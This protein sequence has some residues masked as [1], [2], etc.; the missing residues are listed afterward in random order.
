MIF[1]G[2][3]T[4]KRLLCVLLALLTLM[5]AVAVA[6][7]NAE[8]DAVLADIF[9]KYKTT[10]AVVVVA[11][12]GEIVYHYD[13]GYAYKK[14]R[15]PITPESYFKIASVTKL[16]SAIRV[17]QLVEEGMLDLDAPIGNYF[18]FTIQN[19]HHRA[20]P[21]TLRHLM[22]HTS[23][24]SQ[25]GGYSRE[26]R[27]DTF[28]DASLNHWSNWED[29]APGSKYAYSNFGA[30]LMGSLME[31]VT[32]QNIDDCVREGVFEPLNIDAAYHISLLGDP[33][34]AVYTYRADG[35]LLSSRAAYMR[36]AWEPEIDPN[37][38]YTITVGSVWIRGDD[39]CRLGIMLC[40]GGTIDG[41][42]ILK[43]ETVE[44]MMSSQQGLGHVTV[45]SP[46]GLCVHRVS[47]L[48]DDYM[49]YGHQGLSEGILCNLYFDPETRLV[50][51]LITNGSST[52]MTDH[53]GR[54]S[55]R[56]FAEIWDRYRD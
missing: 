1:E 23:S 3:K 25:R 36:N 10:G 9:P 40:N 43:P 24:L 54:L 56:I 16:V 6:S 49:V 17:M 26:R 18:G 34:K 45:D 7:E 37:A 31:I 19:P 55:R 5:P 8:L 48:L 53:I 21:V 35:S 2:A 15:E 11:K 14:D 13:Y 20:I 28:L 44:L 38:H 42:Q 47:N 46:Y 41:V 39:L 27:L 51:T 33:D 50:F 29:W 30:G 52:N 22:S 32:Q 4:I 12:D